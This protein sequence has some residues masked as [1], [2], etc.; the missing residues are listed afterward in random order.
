MGESTRKVFTLFDREL[1]VLDLILDHVSHLIVDICQVADLVS[2][3]YPYALGIIPV[4][5]SDTR[6]CQILQRLCNDI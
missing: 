6:G 3:I 1:K 2:R 5:E 4:G